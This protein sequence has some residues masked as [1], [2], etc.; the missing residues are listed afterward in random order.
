MVHILDKSIYSGGLGENI[1]LTYLLCHLTK[2]DCD[3]YAISCNGSNKSH[4]QNLFTHEFILKLV[5]I[6]FNILKHVPKHAISRETWWLK[7]G[8]YFCTHNVSNQHVGFSSDFLPSQ[9]TTAI[10]PPPQ[11]T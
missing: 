9:K 11:L 2:R 7:S 6:S 1:N 10:S 4:S 3:I 5:L 8:K